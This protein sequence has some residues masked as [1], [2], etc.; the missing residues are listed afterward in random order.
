V[1]GGASPAECELITIPISHYCEKARWALDLAGVPYRERAHLQVVHWFHV[2]R[3]GGGWTAPVLR[4]GSTVLP[5]SAEIVRWADA[6]AGLGLYPSDDVRELEGDF[7]AN[8]GPH[9]RR[10]MY[11]AIR[12]ADGLVRKYGVTG[13]PAWERRSVPVAFG[14]V[15]R[16]I[17]RYLKIT[18][19][20]AAESLRIVRSV[21]DSVGE[22]LSD[23]RTYLVGD[24]FSAAD[25]AFAALSAP[26]LVP[27]EYGV[28]LPS[29][30]ELPAPMAE[31]VRELRA[32]P[33]GTF[34]LR[35]YRQERRP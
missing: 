2:K 1:S 23:G 6:R 33:A 28:P 17:D 21:F 27:S 16:V 4:C 19:E 24:R 14:L 7:D 10:W 22:R 5:E 34:A 31:V 9:G 18:P 3:A 29:P 30:D 12:G 25:L 32:H 26:V 11:D 13:V 15:S 35:M 8:L 20:S